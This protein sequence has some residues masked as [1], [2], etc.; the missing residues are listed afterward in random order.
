MEMSFVWN[1]I[2]GE[3]ALKKK[4]KTDSDIGME[5]NNRDIEQKRR[6]MAPNYLFLRVEINYKCILVTPWCELW[7]LVIRK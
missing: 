6:S 5:I 1:R 3:S 7:L 4:K 2:K